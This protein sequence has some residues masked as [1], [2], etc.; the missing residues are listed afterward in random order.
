MLVTHMCELDCKKSTPC[1]LRGWKLDGISSQLNL[2]STN[3][4]LIKLSRILEAHTFLL[5]GIGSSWS[6]AKVVIL[7]ELVTFEHTRPWVIVRK[8]PGLTAC[9]NNL[10]TNNTGMDNWKPPS[11]AC[12]RTPW[13]C[14]G[15][16][17]EK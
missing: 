11:V 3:H 7:W 9:L 4:N 1:H 12:H 10:R 8:H 6:N 5:F 16:S 17:I 15:F 14:V 2:C 13:V